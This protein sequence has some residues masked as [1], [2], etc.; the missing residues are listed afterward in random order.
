MKR[1]HFCF[2]A[3]KRRF[4]SEKLEIRSKTKLNEAKKAKR[5]ENEPKNYE[6]VEG[7]VMLQ[8]C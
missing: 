5:N 6:N 3:K 4:R 8:G 2:E 1:K 7:V